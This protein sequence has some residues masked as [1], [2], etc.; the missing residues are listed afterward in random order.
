M[1]AMQRTLSP[2]DGSVY[3]ERELASSAEIDRALNQARAA[4]QDIVEFVEG[5]PAGVYFFAIGSPQ[6]EVVCA[7]VAERHRA[8]G[9]GLCIGAS[10]EFLT[11]AKSRA[12]RWMQRTGTEWLYRLASEPARLWR[13][14][15]VEGP[16]IF[17][18]WWRWRLNS[19]R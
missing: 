14:Y 16:Q 7:M 12:P 9:V 13:R 17:L 2:V 4:Q 19:P 5:C 6:S 11:G 1:A 8:R 10:L 3:V 18:I 15:L